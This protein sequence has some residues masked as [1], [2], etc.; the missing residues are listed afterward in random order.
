MGS[1]THGAPVAASGGR[2]RVP[3][4]GSQSGTEGYGRGV[5]MTE[6]SRD[7][8]L[9]SNVSKVSSK[10]H[11]NINASSVYFRSVVACI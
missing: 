1:T 3:C 5:S 11:E 4:S 6:V 10:Y 8:Q 2:R 7:S 9:P